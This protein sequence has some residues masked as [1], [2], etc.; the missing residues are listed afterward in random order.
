ALWTR[1]LGPAAIAA[2]ARQR[3]STLARHART[4]SPFYRKHWRHLPRGE[5]EAIE[6]RP[7]EVARR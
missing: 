6:P 2:A 1:N 3:W 7:A 4:H 5:D